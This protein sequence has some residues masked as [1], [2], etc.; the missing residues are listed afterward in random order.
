M[1]T[2][3]YRAVNTVGKSLSG[4]DR[5]EFADASSISPWAAEACTAMHKAGIINGVGANSFAPKDNVTRA[6]AAKILYEVMT[7]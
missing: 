5:E 4:A 7:R 6:Q 1:A 3:T 2:M